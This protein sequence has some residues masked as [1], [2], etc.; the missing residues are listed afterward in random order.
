M[1]DFKSDLPKIAN[2]YSEL[3]HPQTDLLAGGR[4][5]V[6]SEARCLV[7]CI[8][9]TPDDQVGLAAETLQLDLDISRVFSLFHKKTDFVGT[10]ENL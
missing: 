4:L 10:T 2:L 1:V 3:G 8:Q 5:S 6:Q 7:V 9:I